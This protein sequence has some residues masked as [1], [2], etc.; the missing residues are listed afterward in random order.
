MAKN[1]HGHVTPEI[2]GLHLLLPTQTKP[3][4]KS[5]LHYYVCD[6]SL[7]KEE[8]NKHYR[9]NTKPS[10]METNNGV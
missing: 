4:F 2:Y 6:V 7:E 3:D 9:H 10:L 5:P 1:C 8:V